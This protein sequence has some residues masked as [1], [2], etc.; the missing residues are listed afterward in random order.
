MAHEPPREDKSL[1]DKLT[2]RAKWL[3]R[4]RRTAEGPQQTVSAEELETER[5]KVLAMLAEGKIDALQAEALLA[6]LE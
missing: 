4:W 5:L 6:A 1:A 3:S 2:K